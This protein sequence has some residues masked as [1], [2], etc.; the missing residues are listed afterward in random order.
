MSGFKLWSAVVRNIEKKKNRNFSDCYL[1]SGVNA[2]ASCHE[3][4]CA[5]SSV[6]IYACLHACTRIFFPGSFELNFYPQRGQSANAELRVFGK[7]LEAAAF[8]VVTCASHWCLEKNR[9]RNPFTPEG[10]Y[11]SRHLIVSHDV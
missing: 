2:R 10:K 8:F 11:C 6:H 5:A 7:G 4:P 9:L 3:P 1:P